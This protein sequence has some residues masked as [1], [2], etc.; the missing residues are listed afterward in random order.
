M[1]I[2]QTFNKKFKEDKMHNLITMIF[3]FVWA[4]VKIVLGIVK[5]SGFLCISAVYTFCLGVSKHMFFKGRKQSKTNEESNREYF[6]FIGIIITI[7]SVCYLVYMIRLFFISSETT[8]GMITAI[9]IAAM[10]FTEL[11]FSIYGL[12]KARKQK[13]LLTEGLKAINLVS[14]LSAIALTQTAIL[15]FTTNGD[16]S[17][18]NGIM[19]T[20]VGAISL[21]L[22]I[23]ITIKALKLIKQTNSIV[24]KD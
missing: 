24:D 12:I 1:G 21:L 20:I 15:S 17:K 4:T 7:A 3:N 22:G 18:Y 11:Y 5:L 6:L 9:A 8:Y 2:K 10:A 23:Y 19:G 13:D 14:A 16:M